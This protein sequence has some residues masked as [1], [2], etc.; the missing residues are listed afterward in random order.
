ME[1]I[2]KTLGGGTTLRYHIPSERRKGLCFNLR[3]GGSR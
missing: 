3:K 1:K 2:L